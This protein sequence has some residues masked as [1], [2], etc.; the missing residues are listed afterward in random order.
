LISIVLPVPPTTNELW[1]PV[2][3][4]R[5]AKLVA[6]AAYRDWKAMAKREVE[7]QREGAAIRGGF[8]AAILTPEGAFDADN[9]IKPTLDACQAGG[10][11]GNDKH[12]RGGSWDVDDTRVG[13]VLVVLTPIPPPA[14]APVRKR[15]T[16]RKESIS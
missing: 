1:A 14:S 9:L 7:V 8:R 13:T 15:A 12:C 3:T 4:Q 5:G 6:R 16:A 10:A 2:A 11:I